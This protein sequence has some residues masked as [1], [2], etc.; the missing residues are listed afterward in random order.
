MT[1]K[2]RMNSRESAYRIKEAIREKT[3]KLDFI[4]VADAKKIAFT[5]PEIEEGDAK[6]GWRWSDLK[7]SNLV[8]RTLKGNTH[9]LYICEPTIKVID[10]NNLEQNLTIDKET[11]ARTTITPTGLVF[12]KP[13]SDKE[14]IDYLI[15]SM[16]RLI[17]GKQ[18]AMVHH[19]LN[20]KTVIERPCWFHKWTQNIVV[21]DGETICQDLAI[22]EFPEDGHIERIAWDHIRFVEE[23]E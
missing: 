4:S 11:A 18:K 21:R 3:N 5:M 7:G 14:Q 13:M 8:V 22:C 16:S 10:V 15:N 23:W 17:G 9:W 1:L 2:W 12:E 6:Q 20:K 19:K